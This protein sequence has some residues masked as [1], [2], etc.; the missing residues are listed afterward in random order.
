[1]RIGAALIRFNG[2]TGRCIVTGLDPDSGRGD[3]PTLELLRLAD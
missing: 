3:M 2:H 1:V